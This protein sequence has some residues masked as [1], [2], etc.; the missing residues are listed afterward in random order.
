MITAAHLMMMMI[1]KINIGTILLLCLT[2]SGLQAQHT[3]G[4]V[5]TSVGLSFEPVKDFTVD[6]SEEV[7]YNVSIADLYQMNSNIAIDYKLNKKFKTGVDYRYSIRDG[8][9]TNRLGW[10][11]SYKEGFN[12][13]ALSMRTKFQYSP[14][15]DGAEGTSWRNKIGLSYEINKD[16]SPFVSGELFYLFSN[17]L[18]QFETYRFEAGIDYGPNKHHDYTLSWLYD[19]E[20]NVNN[21]DK[22]HVLTVGYKYSF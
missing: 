2:V 20:F 5:W 4:G 22:M 14:V 11:L 1:K 18:D 12:D 10:G 21:P 7:R 6:V 16:W 17:E 15:P 19:H 13:F 3:D 9:N 8:R